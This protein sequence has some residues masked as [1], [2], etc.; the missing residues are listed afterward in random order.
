MASKFF[1]LS[2]DSDKVI[3]FP[4]ETKEQTMEK[5]TVENVSLKTTELMEKPGKLKSMKNIGQSSQTLQTSNDID[6]LWA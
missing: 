1:K 3:E 6:E 5:L 4:N 2:M